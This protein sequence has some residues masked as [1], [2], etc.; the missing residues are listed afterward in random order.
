MAYG[1]QLWE[2]EEKKELEKIK[3]DYL[4]WVLKLDFCTP[5]YLIYQETNN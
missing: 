5:R 3:A 4:R 1:V 2:W